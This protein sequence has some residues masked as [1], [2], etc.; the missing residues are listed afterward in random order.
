MRM[1]IAVAFACCAALL[2]ILPQQ[3]AFGA[4]SLPLLDV[5]AVDTSAAPEI[6]ITVTVPRQLSG[7]NLDADNF[8]I[9][10]AGK[11]RIPDMTR[12]P[13]DRLAVVLAIDT[14]G[15]MEGA[16]IQS[17]KASAV[18]F[19]RKM[20]R[21]TEVAIVG[22]NSAATV[23]SPF[24]TDSA[25][26]VATIDGVQAA[27]E[28]ALYDGVTAASALLASAGD[29]RRA[30]VILSDGRDTA[31]AASLEAATGALSNTGADTYV[32]SLATGETDLP[33]LQA[34]ASATS[35]R[36]VSAADPGA[37][38]A[39][40]DEIA[41]A[42]T[43]QYEFTFESISTGTVPVRISVDA[44]GVAAAAEFDVDTGTKEAV[45]AVRARPVRV[46]TPD[47]PLL[48]GA[49]WALWLGAVLVFGALLAAG[50]VL[51]APRDRPSTIA[52]ER[53]RAQRPRRD[54]AL[55]ELVGNAAR[56][57][58]RTLERRGKRNTLNEALE[59]ASIDMRPG[60]FVVLAASSAVAGL[61]VGYLLFGPLVA[62]AVAAAVVIGFRAA[63]RVR[64]DR[65]RALFAE[66]LGDT[67]QLMAGS[68][69]SGHGLLQAIDTVAE[70]AEAPTSD[71]FRR[72]VVET[73]LGK[74][75]PDAL[76][77]AAARVGNED[78]NWVVQA[79]GIHRDVGGDLAEVLDH[80]ASTIRSR[81]SVRRQVKTLSA[82][83]RLSAVILF[84]LPLVLT[85]VI[86]IVNPEYLQELTGDTMGNVMIAAGIALLGIGGL[87]LKRITRIVF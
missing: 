5:V 49:E 58:D 41:L 59:R 14:S 57:A 4:E 56:A 32:A 44:E 60:E 18:D 37:L 65:R 42:I 16:P 40:Y 72:I 12:L 23:L 67:L 47:T 52:A 63:V 62:L 78:F 25:A 45:A 73:R 87:W 64:A 79:I 66:Q 38:G 50:W 61:F 8:A 13:S 11:R 22:F 69:R 46:T 85:V 27:G 77:A 53:R 7:A 15:S 29:A 30:T 1:R 26:L 81:N 55:S 34:L 43:N 3:F 6:R 17:A 19:V 20:P 86:A 71:E 76:D 70:E 54:Q 51:L 36:L 31:S 68:L 28:T 83:G 39:A 74:N 9:E 80:V 75:L 84:L 10:E 33:A 35:G 21:G 24:T 82:E 48:G 2:V